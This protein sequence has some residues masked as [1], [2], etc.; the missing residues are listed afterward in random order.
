VPFNFMTELIELFSFPFVQRGIIA[1]VCVALV[2][3]LLSVFVVL[4]K[5]AFIGQG[6]SHSAFARSFSSGDNR[7]SIPTFPYAPISITSVTVAG[8]FWCM[9]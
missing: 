1:G 7:F 5:M 9:G 3:S 6:I 4:K 8:K 2:C